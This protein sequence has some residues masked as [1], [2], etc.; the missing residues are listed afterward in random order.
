MGDFKKK[1]KIEKIELEAI[2]CIFIMSC[3]ILDIVSFVFRNVFNTNIS[4]STI[5]R[6]VIPITV[7][8][9]IF[10]KNKFKLKT[11]IVGFIYL[12]YGVIHLVI[13]NQVKNESSYSTLIHEAQY[14]INYSFMILNL[15]IYLYAFSNKNT[16]KLKKSVF[17]SIIT[18]VLSIY[19]AILTGT[20]SSTYIEGLGYKGWFESGNSISAILIL[21]MFMILGYVKD[22]EYRKVATALIV[23]M[24]IF[25]TT[26]I[27]TRVG[28][29]GFIL[30]LGLYIIIEIIFGLIKKGKVNK[31]LIF[32]G[33]GI[34]IVAIIVITMLGSN[35]LKR[36]QHLKD[37]EENIVDE[38]IGGEAHI[39]GDLLDIREKIVDGTLEEGYMSEANIQSII[40]LYNIANEKKI[41][42]N[43]MRMQQLIYN[44]SLVKNQANPIL[45]LFGNGFNTQ[46]RELVMEME[47]VALLLNFGLIGFILYV[48]PFLVLF[49][50]SLYIGIKNIKKVDAEYVMLFLGSGLVYMLSLLSGY[51]FFNSSTMMFIIVIYTLLIN[52]AL[53]IGGKL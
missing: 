34:L 12:I 20:S 2:L 6:P 47:L 15:F 35:T 49:M 29:Y 11:V 48:G 1:L 26:L 8:I 13:F 19:V 38:T 16:Q 36:R 32:S 46:F 23:L 4:P 25:L 41:S 3:P 37:I 43:D 39:S 21:S 5:I 31:K 28:L 18:Y 14:I 7:I 50:Y 24:G 9:Y 30:V 33:I 52:K 40:D 22:K 17:V 27:G 45:I 53:K 42:N 44:V 51:T 10:F